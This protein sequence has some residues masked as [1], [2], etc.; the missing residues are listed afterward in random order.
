[1]FPRGHLGYWGT[2]LIQIPEGEILKVIDP[3]S[4]ENIGQITLEKRRLIFNDQHIIN[5]NG[6]EWIG[7]SRQ[8]FLKVKESND[9]THF[10]FQINAN[11]KLGL[12][13]K[14]NLTKISG[15][16]YS[17]SELLFEDDLGPELLE[18]R[19]MSNVGVNLNMNCLNLRDQPKT[20]ALKYHCI[21]GND[22][23]TYE[24]SHLT[25]L[26]NELNWAKVEVVTIFDNCSGDEDARD[27][28]V[29]EKFRQIG[30]IKAIDENGF[31]NIWYSVTSY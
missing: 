3:I 2:G 10:E 27:C 9:R 20:N 7:S 22:W 24:Y 6:V 19:K 30:W 23:P 31:P 21:P 5:W 15:E 8:D 25:I 14:I 11:G 12:M 28:D 18:L 26:D 1:M 29:Y 17:Y 13:T 4:K 16:Y